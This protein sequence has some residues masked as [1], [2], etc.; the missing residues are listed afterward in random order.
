MVHLNTDKLSVAETIVK[1]KP[2]LIDQVV[3][4]AEQNE[5]N[6]YSALHYAAWQG[7]LK[8]V[9]ML[10]KYGADPNLLTYDG[11]TAVG[12]ACHADSMP[13]VQ[14]LLSLGCD[15][16][17]Q[18]NDGDTALIYASHNGNSEMV[19]ELLQHNANPSLCNNMNISPLWN[20]VYSR[21][22]ASVQLLLARNVD[23]EVECRGQNIYEEQFD[24]IYDVP[25]SPLFVAVH[26][27]ELSIIK[28]LVAAG[29]YLNAEMFS[30]PTFDMYVDMWAE[31]NKRWLKHVTSNPPSLAWW[32]KKLIRKKLLKVD[33]LNQVEKLNIP[34]VLKTYLLEV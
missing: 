21:S 34:F 28:A 30:V 12:L 17:Q 19:K 1:F 3:T 32:C 4:N 16:N 5:S 25:V 27:E 24:Q 10:C 6:Y 2:D 33:P 23:A 18:D 9:Q 26:H 29:C 13:C 11:N 8:G 7:N 14:Y 15:T 31:E 22:L 20:A